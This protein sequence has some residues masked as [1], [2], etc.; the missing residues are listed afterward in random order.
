MPLCIHTPPPAKTA[1]FEIVRSRQGDGL[2]W[3]VLGGSLWVVGTVL[4]YSV[5]ERR[6]L[7]GG[8][9]YCTLI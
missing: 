6:S 3:G 7:C 4:A 8:D 5:P 2:S 1:K 9:I